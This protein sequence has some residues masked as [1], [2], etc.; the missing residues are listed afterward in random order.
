MKQQS[1]SDLLTRIAQSPV[2][3]GELKSAVKLAKL[4]TK[5]ADKFA[6][7]RKERKRISLPARIIAYDYETTNIKAG[8][9]R[10]LW[11]TAYGTG[12]EFESRIRDMRHLG[13]ILTTQFLTP[14]N[15]GVKFVGWNANRFDAYFTAAALILNDEFSIQPYLTK[16]KALRGMRVS[17][18]VNTD[19]TLAD[20]DNPPTWE[21]LDGIAMLG[22]AGTTL[23]KF[24][25]SFAPDYK[26]LSGVIDFESGETFDPGN[27]LH[28][29]YAMR[30]SV[31]LYHGM[32]RAQNIMLA[33]FNEPLA[34]TM[35]G[36]C[37]KIF[38][39]HIPHNVVI[40]PLI[41]D[42]TQIMREYVMRGG[43]CVLHRRYT[44]PIWKYDINQA[45]AAAM[46]DAYLPCGDAMHGFG[47]PRLDACFIALVRA[48]K[49]G[50][51]IPFYIR[52]EING[53]IRSEFATDTIPE[54]W[55]T[56]IEIRQ[57][58]SEA[59]SITYLEFWQW[60]DTFSMRDYVNK[61]ERMRG[62]AADGPKGAE[63]TMIKATG[64]HS[65]GKTLEDI[66]PIEYLL[67]LECPDDAHPYF[68]IGPEPIA[69]LFY[70]T[71][72]DRK[73]KAYHQPH[74]GSFITAHVRMVLR[75]VILLRPESWIYADTDCLVFDSDMTA[76]MDI[77]AAR[78]GAWK[79]EETGETW[80]M[81]AKKVYAQVLP[82]DSKVK[83]IHHAKGMHVRKL[84]PEDFAKWEAGEPPTQNQ[85]QINNFLAVL[86]GADMYRAQ[87]RR[88]TAVKAPTS[89]KTAAQMP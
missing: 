28:R 36:V 53:R 20:P 5:H 19:G 27:K 15:E 3:R 46:R 7:V 62:A 69:H 24:L 44:G 12:F 10:P 16:S 61:L 52:A 54:T 71:V 41:P 31:G 4:K 40:K 76:Q 89:P 56:S 64:N 1:N 57:L 48:R 68:D 80:R 79:I 8:T 39:A 35:G 30:D 33:G 45:Y 74:I 22:L 82:D 77:D 2:K 43:F 70:R 25:E 18:R 87:T 32:Q 78:Y 75:R 13:L 50:N 84:S 17:R 26:K 42:L 49:P 65:Y 73:S 29:E 38:Q 88:G 63:G 9:P 37:I 59:W 85:I 11:L 83:P 66:E 67:A 86:C 6:F 72:L 51:T 23:E 60:S 14:E 34:V 47:K 58:E 81:I 21:F 55:L